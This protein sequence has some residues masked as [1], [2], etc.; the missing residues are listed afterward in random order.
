M[1][2]VREQ[3]TIRVVIECNGCGRKLDTSETLPGDS[4]R[5]GNTTQRA[6]YWLDRM[7]ERI[8]GSAKARRWEHVDRD[9]KGGG[10]ICAHCTAAEV[11]ALG[12]SVTTRRG[13]VGALCG[14]C[15][16]QPH[17]GPC[18]ASVDPAG[19]TAATMDKVCPCGTEAA[20][21]VHKIRPGTTGVLCGIHAC[22]AA[23]TSSK[24]EDTTCPACLR[25]WINPGEAKAM[26]GGDPAARILW[27]LWCAPRSTVLHR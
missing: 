13:P 18:L 9:V 10:W 7:R 23:T 17:Q 12:D 1:N 25:L 20:P 6:E 16:H 8:L 26:A 15:P 2:D 27:G 4:L 5:T 11:D 19:L 14:Q 3:V 22:D 21:I 24:R